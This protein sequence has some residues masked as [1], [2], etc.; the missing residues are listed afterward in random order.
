MT[1]D[2]LD[3]ITQPF[4]WFSFVRNPFTRVLSAY[5]DK[6]IFD[7][8]LRPRKLAFGLDNPNMTITFKDFLLRLIDISVDDMDVH[9]AP[10][11]SL[12]GLTNEMI[13]YSFLGRLEKFETDIKLV[14]D[15]LDLPYHKF[16]ST[17]GMEHKTGAARLI[18]Q[19][20][21]VSEIELVREIYK[22]D[23]SLLG[24]SNN[25]SDIFSYPKW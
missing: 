1:W 20:Y 10:Q 17:R 9:F 8:E 14:L 12:L 19:Y 22:Q 21:G 16:L 18:N 15:L 5:L 24:Y 13:H 11:S 2:G 23:F 3:A 25:I 7:K 4:F 6:F